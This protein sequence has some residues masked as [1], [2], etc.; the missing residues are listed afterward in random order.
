MLESTS[1]EEHRDLYLLNLKV[2][3]VPP[4]S[5]TLV[6]HEVGFQYVKKEFG[7]NKRSSNNQFIQKQW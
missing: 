7:I 4:Y 3:W 5:L 2:M 1:H 6:L